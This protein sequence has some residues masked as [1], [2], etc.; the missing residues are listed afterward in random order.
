MKEKALVKL[1]KSGLVTDK[2]S[3]FKVDINGALIRTVFKF[4]YEVTK[5]VRYFEISETSKDIYDVLMD[6]YN[7][8]GK[9]KRADFKE[10]LIKAINKG[11]VSSEIVP[12]ELQ[13][14]IA[15]HLHSNLSNLNLIR[16]YMTIYSLNRLEPIQISNR[17]FFFLINL[18]GGFFISEKMDNLVNV[19]GVVKVEKVI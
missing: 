11:K 3:V 18:D 17:G 12:D 14:L 4:I 7:L 1:F 16:K 9:V 5:D 19:P 6:I 13:N 15:T 2:F 10:S 8:K